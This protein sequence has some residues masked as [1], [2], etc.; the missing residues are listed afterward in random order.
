MGAIPAPVVEMMCRSGRLLSLFLETDAPYR[1]SNLT[2]LD[3]T[4]GKVVAQGSRADL[5]LKPAMDEVSQKT[6]GSD[7]KGAWI[8]KS[9]LWDTTRCGAGKNNMSGKEW[10][11][12][13]NDYMDRYPFILLCD[14][15]NY[16]VIRVMLIE[17]KML[18]NH[19]DISRQ[20]ESHNPGGRRIRNNFTKVQHNYPCYFTPAMWDAEA[21]KRKLVRLSK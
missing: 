21:D 18:Q 3:P 6:L 20:G 15:R 17:T 14:K 10:D 7:K 5:F 11:T 19:A 16:P 1:F 9:G 8:T 2:Q 4:T 12:Q 13:H